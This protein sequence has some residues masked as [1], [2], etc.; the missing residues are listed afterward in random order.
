[1]CKCQKKMKEGKGTV[2]SNDGPYGLSP[3]SLYGNTRSAASA[4]SNLCRYFSIAE[5]KAATNDFDESLLLGVGG[6]GKVYRGEIDGGITK[7]AIKRANPMSDQGVHQFQTEIEMLSMLRHNHLVSLIGYCEE[8]CEMILVYDYMA[9]GT[10]REN[11]CK[12]QKP[13]LS[14][15]QR[16]E[17]CIGAARGL[18]YLHTGAKHTIIHR[19]VKATNILLDDKGLQSFRFRPLEDWSDRRHVLCQHDGEGSFG[20]F[21]PEYFRRCSSQRNLMSTLLG[22]CCLR[23]CVLG[24]LLTPCFQMKR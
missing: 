17:I 19:D 14:W 21:D 2:T 1:M 10:L 24:Q 15:K 12:T 8:N 6:F 18:H 20:Y 9:Q 7:V 5:I 16:L 3:L 11:L 13:P 23:S 4:E 22:S